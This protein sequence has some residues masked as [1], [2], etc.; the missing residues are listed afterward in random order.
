MN[1]DGAGGGGVGVGVGNVKLGGMV[2]K[3]PYNHLILAKKKGDEGREG[4]DEVE[5]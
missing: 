1:P 3:V 2:D 4:Y 5:G